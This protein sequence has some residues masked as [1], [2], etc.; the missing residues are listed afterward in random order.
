LS[1]KREIGLACGRP[2]IGIDRFS[3]YRALHETGDLLV[4]LNSKRAELFC[5]FFPA[6]GAAHDSCLMTEQ[7]I[8]AFKTSHSACKIAGD[9][10]T[11]DDDILAAC[12]KLAA[13]A[14]AKNPDFLPRPLY[15]RAP[16]V[17]FPSASLSKSR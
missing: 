2:V 15:L 6:Q 11:A 3:A 12:A 13:Q 17:T 4:V 9:L 7:E 1:L 14:D 8:N 5:R 10:A 16:D